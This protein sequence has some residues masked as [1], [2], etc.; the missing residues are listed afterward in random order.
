MKHL[1]IYFKKS[2]VRD[3]GNI[4]E[5]FKLRSITVEGKVEVTLYKELKL[6][7]HKLENKSLLETHF[8]VK[9]FTL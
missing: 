4:F 1:D 7:K 8:F 9:S 5:E 2:S 6:F 3:L